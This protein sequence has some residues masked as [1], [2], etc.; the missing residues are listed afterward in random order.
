MI[1]GVKLTWNGL[2]PGKGLRL[3]HHFGYARFGKSETD[4]VP[5]S[6][7]P[8]SMFRAKFPALPGQWRIVIFD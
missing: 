6:L 1:L 3:V 4:L 7:M 2:A 8:D 5:N